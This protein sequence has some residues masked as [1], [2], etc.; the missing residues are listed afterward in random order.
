MVTKVINIMNAY[1]YVLFTA[2]Y[3]NYSENSHFNVHIKF[4]SMNTRVELYF[5]ER[6]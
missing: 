1:L 5:K 2:K 6:G 3:Y 4:I